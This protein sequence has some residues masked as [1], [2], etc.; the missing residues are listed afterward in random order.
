MASKKAKAVLKTTKKGTEHVYSQPCEG[1]LDPAYFVKV[2]MKDGNY[3]LAKLI[4]CKLSDKYDPKKPLT[5]TSYDYYVHYVDFDRRMDEWV[6]RSR[7][8]LTRTLV[9]E[10]ELKKKQ[11]KQEE[12]ILDSEIENEHAGRKSTYSDYLTHISLRH[13]RK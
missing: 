11:K 10:E 7:I 2:Q 9:L 8:E 13:D 3:H 12:E 6:S 5:D 4:D 1:A